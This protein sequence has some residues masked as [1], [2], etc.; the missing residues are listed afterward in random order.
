MKY[1]CNIIDLSYI[2]EFIVKIVMSDW[3]DKSDTIIGKERLDDIYVRIIG[4]NDEQIKARVGLL[5]EQ[6][7]I[8]RGR[9]VRIKERK[10]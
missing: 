8:N 7:S 9:G 5:K 2:P 10:R 3:F 6:K 4:D 1:Y